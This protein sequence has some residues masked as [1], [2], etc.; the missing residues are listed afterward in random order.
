MTIPIDLS[1]IPD[2]PSIARPFVSAFADQMETQ[3]TA[4]D[5]D[6]GSGFTS[7]SPGSLLAGAAKHVGLAGI[8][9]AIQNWPKVKE[10][11]IDAANYLAMCATVIVHGYL[12][13]ALPATPGDPPAAPDSSAASS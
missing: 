4:N 8:E 1:A 9:A 3:L 5:A 11:V 7:A 10:H 2:V 13:Q 6:K 12:D